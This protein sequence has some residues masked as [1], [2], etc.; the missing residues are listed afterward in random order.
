[1]DAIGKSFSFFEIGPRDLGLKVGRT[2]CNNIRIFSLFNSIDESMSSPS[3]GLKTGHDI[4][5]L[6][7]GEIVWVS[8]AFATLT[9]YFNFLFIQ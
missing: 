3:L 2:C 5:H 8:F 9:V 7:I 4:W 6:G 1:M